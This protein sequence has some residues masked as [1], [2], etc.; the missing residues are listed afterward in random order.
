MGIPNCHKVC[1]KEHFCISPCAFKIMLEFF[2]CV[3][4]FRRA[5]TLVSV[6]GTGVFSEP[7]KNI[8]V[9]NIHLNQG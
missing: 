4:T 6:T 1:K 5:W 8:V 2:Q 9:R 7:F 3:Y